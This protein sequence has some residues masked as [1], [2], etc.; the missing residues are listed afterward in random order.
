MV[1]NLPAVLETWVWS[2]GQEDPLEEGMTLHSSIL[3]GEF[4]G[5]RSLVDYSPWGLKESNMT[6][7]LTRSLTL[8]VPSLRNPDNTEEKNGWE[9]GE[10]DS[11]CISVL[12]HS[13]TFLQFMS[14][15]WTDVLAC[16]P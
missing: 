16:I 4:H 13:V 12:N 10:L 7:Q 1:K 2:L 9:I 6:E 8:V 3:S 14:Q 15:F 5:H 11:N